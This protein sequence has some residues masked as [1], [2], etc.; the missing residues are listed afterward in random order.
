MNVLSAGGIANSKNFSTLPVDK[1]GIHR[2]AETG[3]GE[4]GRLIQWLKKF[5][6]VH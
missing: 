6:N 2:C 4:L 3:F 1:A 5:K